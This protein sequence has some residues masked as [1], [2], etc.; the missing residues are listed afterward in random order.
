MAKVCVDFIRDFSEISG[1]I[2]CHTIEWRDT[3]IDNFCFCGRNRQQPILGAWIGFRWMF[4]AEFLENPH[5]DYR[6]PGAVF[7]REFGS[8]PPSVERY[9]AALCRGTFRS[10]V[11]S[12]QS[13]RQRADT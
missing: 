2:H 6:D 9:G 1:G 3:A 5:V 4:R 7:C 10:D 12:A 8:E 11:L 13:K